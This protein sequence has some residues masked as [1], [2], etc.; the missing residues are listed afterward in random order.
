MKAIF[1]IMTLPFSLFENPLL[2]YGVMTIIGA[3]AFR[4]AWD[5][6]GEIGIRG[7]LGSII[8]WTIRI[9]VFVFVWAIIS[10]IIWLVLFV[11]NNWIFFVIIALLITKLKVM[12]YIS[13]NNENSILN[14]K[15]I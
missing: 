4:V 9:M 15:I 7:E 6:T 10:A 3:I 2:D 12:F 8:H 14:K 5:L 1:E 13:K 11:I